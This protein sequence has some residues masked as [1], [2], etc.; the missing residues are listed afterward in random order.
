MQFDGIAEKVLISLCS[1]SKLKELVNEFLSDA[2]ST[3][4]L[5]RE[6]KEIGRRE[7]ADRKFLQNAHKIERNDERES[8]EDRRQ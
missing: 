8:K 5:A 1:V 3:A 4:H 2:Y 7:K 6:G